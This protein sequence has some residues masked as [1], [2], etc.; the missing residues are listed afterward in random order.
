MDVFFLTSWLFYLFC[1]GLSRKTGGGT[2]SVEEAGGLEG[3]VIGKAATFPARYRQCCTERVDLKS[4][5]LQFR[6]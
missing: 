5:G 2:L 1:R 3:G 6:M 4:E